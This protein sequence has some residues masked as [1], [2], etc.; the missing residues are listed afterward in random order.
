[1]MKRPRETNPGRP[2]KRIK[3]DTESSALGKSREFAITSMFESHSVRWTRHSTFVVPNEVI[4]LEID[5]EDLGQVLPHRS[6]SADPL[7]SITHPF[8]EHGEDHYI[9]P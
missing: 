8:D 6:S 3:L 1:M 9:P 5:D 4:E 7:D 2:S